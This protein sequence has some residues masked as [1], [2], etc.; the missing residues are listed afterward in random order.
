M[1]VAPLM[2]PTPNKPPLLLLMPPVTLRP[3]LLMMAPP[4]A[5]VSPPVKDDGPVVAVTDSTDSAPKGNGAW[6][7]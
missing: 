3:P 5:T 6:C 7:Y 4:L 2:A 1:V